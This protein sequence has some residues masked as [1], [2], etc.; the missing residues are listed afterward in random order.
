MEDNKS[1]VS[2][3]L[4]AV[5][6]VLKV[7]IDGTDEALHQAYRRSIK[8]LAEFSMEFGDDGEPGFLDFRWEFI[9]RFRVL[10]VLT[11]GAGITTDF[12]DIPG[13]SDCIW[14][15]YDENSGLYTSNDVKGEVLN[16]KETFGIPEAE[17][18]INGEGVSEVSGTIELNIPD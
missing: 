2:T 11:D 15:M 16:A 12:S 10:T 6:T 17:Y 1:Y 5:T 14:V 3:N 9:D 18:E 8:M 13:L 7:F 4:D